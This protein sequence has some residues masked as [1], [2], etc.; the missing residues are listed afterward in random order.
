MTTLRREKDAFEN[1][2]KAKSEMVIPEDRE[3]RDVDNSVL[4]RGGID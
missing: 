2:I 4:A 1:L 3:G